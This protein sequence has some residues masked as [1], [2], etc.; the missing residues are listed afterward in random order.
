MMGF[1]FRRG[2]G[3]TKGRAQL[4]VNAVVTDGFDENMNDVV[5]L[6]YTERAQPDLGGALNYSYDL[7]ALPLGNVTGAFTAVA[8]SFQTVAQASGQWQQAP[9]TASGGNVTGIFH[10]QPLLNPFGEG[11]GYD[12]YGD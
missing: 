4:P 5:H 2:A 12:I 9:I 3:K 11:S 7:Y 10:F 6:H 1:I 8:H